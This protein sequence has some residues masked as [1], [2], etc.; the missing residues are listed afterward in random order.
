MS[1]GCADKEMAFHHQVR[2]AIHS[3]LGTLRNFSKGCC[4][5]LR[6]LFAR[7]LSLTLLRHSYLNAVDWNKLTIAARENLAAGMCHS[8]ETQGTY[9]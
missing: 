3:K 4:A 9:K 8:T 2:L 5:V 6:K 1:A 7:P